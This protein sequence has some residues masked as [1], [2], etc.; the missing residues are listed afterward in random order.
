MTKKLG[1][2]GWPISH[3]FSPKLH[4][5]ISKELGYD[6]VYEAIAVKP[7]EL[8]MQVNNLKNTGICG[9]NVT[10]PH[11]I[12]IMKYID[13]VSDTA[14]TF[15]SVNT[16]VN[17][18]GKLIGY[19]TDAEGFYRSLRY[20][21]IT[22]ESDD[23]LV[24]GAGGAARPAVMYLAK[25]G[26]RSITVI[27]RTKERAQSL[28]SVIKDDCGYDINTEMRLTHYDLVVN[29]TSLGMG[30]NIG[31]SPVSEMPFADAGTVAVDMIYN[32]EQTAFLKI[33]E[34]KGARIING[35]AMLIFQG[36]LAYELFTGAK[37]PDA[38]TD[39]IFKEVFG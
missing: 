37:V 2:I 38:M 8:G 32:P 22:P 39:R 20:Y 15:G 23:I 4:N 27:N 30:K 10:A 17:R 16:V 21:G 9:F 19:N 25:K 1:V 28:R 36:I 13:A 7:E 29:C 34:S 31:L 14:K 5:F 24:Y 12:E 6:Y 3:S 18:C 11:K 35:K 33:A 26:A